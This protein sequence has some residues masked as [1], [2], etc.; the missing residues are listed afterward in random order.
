M[1][2]LWQDLRFAARVLRTNPGFT[3]VAVLALGLGVG[4]NTAIFSVVN[5][6]LLRPQPYAEAE[7]LVSVWFTTAGE[8]QEG[9]SSFKNFADWRAQTRSFEEMA[10]YKSVG[11]TLTGG[12]E[13]QRVQG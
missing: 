2:T 5:G 3:A 11:Y 9:F 4:A 1:L 12:G 8:R 10:S 6:V 7:R 13:P